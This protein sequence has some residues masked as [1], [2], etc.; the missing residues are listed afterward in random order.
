MKRSNPTRI[1]LL[2]LT[3]LVIAVSCRSTQFGQC[4][5][6]QDFRDL[7]KALLAGEAVCSLSWSDH[8]TGERLMY[9]LE[10]KRGLDELAKW[11]HAN[12][13]DIMF[14]RFSG[15]VSRW[16]LSIQR[17]GETPRKQFGFWHIIPL[18][19]FVDFPSEDDLGEIFK[20]HG[21]IEERWMPR[22]PIESGSSE[23]P[24]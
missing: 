11:I 13:S 8:S 21:I 10:D 9:R 22:A 20:R 23:K 19:D 12:R 17:A 6:C 3:V 7:Q 1:P 5:D 14:A 16:F 24:E 15:V 2:L 4:P 18:T